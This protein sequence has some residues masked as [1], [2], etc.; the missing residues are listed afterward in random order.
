[1]NTKEK[2]LKILSDTKREGIG[3]VQ[4]FLEESTYFTDPASIQ[5]HNSY[6]GGLA[7]HCLNV[8]EILQKYKIIYPE[9]EN[10]DDSIAIISFLHPLNHVG[11]YQ[12]TTKNVPLKG[13]DGKNKKNEN[14]KLIF[15]E[16]ESYDYILEHNLPYLEGHLSTILIKQKIKLSKLEDLAITWYMGQ[17]NIS[18]SSFSL[19]DRALA[20]HKLIMLF[21]FAIK[22]ACLYFYGKR[23]L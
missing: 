22:E 23:N 10:L 16:R 12:K 4:K 6:D 19:L 15:V 18:N 14:G 2:I 7:D 13:E 3:G 1:M 11:C 17:Y 9:L 21:Q 8:Y 5:R 20:T